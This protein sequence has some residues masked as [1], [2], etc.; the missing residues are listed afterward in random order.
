MPAAQ[1]SIADTA[2]PTI[3]MSERVPQFRSPFRLGSRR[4]RRIK[5]AVD[6]QLRTIVTPFLI[7]RKPVGMD[8]HNILAPPTL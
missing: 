2:H 6:Y 7:L 1:P 3:L 5:I 8:E 4:R